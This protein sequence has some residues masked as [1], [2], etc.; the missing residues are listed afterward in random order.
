MQ[1]FKDL[2]SK[3]AIHAATDGGDDTEFERIAQDEIKLYR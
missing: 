1:F 2:G 3:C